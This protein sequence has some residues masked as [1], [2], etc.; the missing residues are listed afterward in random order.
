M[1]LGIA[2]KESIMLEVDVAAADGR[3]LHAY[4]VGPTGRAD[5]LVLLWHGGT[6]NTGAPPEPLFDVADSLGIRWIGYDRGLWHV[7]RC[8]LT[9][10]LRQPP[11]HPLRHGQ[12]LASTSSPECQ[13]ALPEN[14]VLPG[15]DAALSWSRSLLPMNL[16]PSRLLL[17]TMQRWMATGPGSTAFSKPQPRMGPTA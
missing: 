12:H 8:L 2:L 16:I 7:P 17:P 10:Y 5:E 4:D 6:P 13:M 15:R 1:E 3:V 9:G 14:C 11:S